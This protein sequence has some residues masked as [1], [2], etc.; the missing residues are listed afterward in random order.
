[1]TVTDEIIQGNFPLKSTKGNN[2]FFYAGKL[3]LVFMLFVNSAVAKNIGIS[4]GL[5]MSNR[6]V[7][8]EAAVKAGTIDLNWQLGGI[9]LSF[10][11]SGSYVPSQTNP[12]QLEFKPSERLFNFNSKYIKAAYG[13]VSPSFSQFTL[14]APS[15]EMGTTVNIDISGFKIMPVYLLLQEADRQ[16]NKMRKELTGM[17]IE[18]SLWSDKINI[19]FGGYLN[20]DDENSLAN[21]GENSPQEILTTGGKL[22][23]K[24]VTGL[25]LIF[26]GAQSKITR[27]VRLSSAPVKR[28]A[29]TVGLNLNWDK[30]NI[31]TGYSFFAKGFL[32][33]G[34]ESAESDKKKMSS[35]FGYSFSDYINGNF[36]FSREMD[37]ISQSYKEIVNKDNTLINLDF[38]FPKAPSISINHSGMRTS[39]RRFTLNNYNKEYGVNISYLIPKWLLGVNISGE[40]RLSSFKDFTLQSDPTRT[41]Y[42][43]SSLNIP[44]PLWIKINLTPNISYSRDMN[45]KTKN[46]NYNKNKSLAVSLILFN[47]KAVLNFA[48]NQ[49]NNYDLLGTANAQNT[50]IT[51]TMNIDIIDHMKLNFNV[52]SSTAED[53]ITNTKT[54]TK[55][56]IISTSITF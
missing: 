49:S 36:D 16:E 39:N 47:G 14:N 13:N 24:P 51:G 41:H 33:A 11:G 52:S 19:G 34:T 22:T 50:G 53:L 8:G 37:G 18:K 28:G 2:S 32:S 46:V 40:A 20:Q 7:P 56:A 35:S 1:L 31:R 5:D 6:R 38:N 54:K 17:G 45:L 30:W 44:I 55:E 15:N 29:Y 21:W 10:R 26:D 48:G 12:G 3:L 27:D 43:S 4:G 23:I 25:E 9:S 42:Y